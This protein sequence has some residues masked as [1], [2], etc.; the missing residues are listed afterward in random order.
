MAGLLTEV[1]HPR[2]LDEQE[3]RKF[4]ERCCSSMYELARNVAARYCVQRGYVDVPAT[5]KSERTKKL[6]F[7]IRGKGMTS[8]DRPE[9]I[10]PTLLRHVAADGK[11]CFGQVVLR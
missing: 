4:A 10:R 6:V 7:A 8:W 9:N 5:S 11:T 2:N 1:T 3:L